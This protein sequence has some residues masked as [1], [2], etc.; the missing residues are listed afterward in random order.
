MITKSGLISTP[1]E[2]TGQYK[3]LY[4]YVGNFTQTAIENT[5][6]LNAELFNEKVDVDFDNMT[7]SSSAK[8]TIVGW[9]LPDFTTLT[10]VS[11]LPFTATQDCWVFITADRNSNSDSAGYITVNGTNL[12]L[13]RNVTNSMTG[14]ATLQIPVKAGTQIGV[15]GNAKFNRGYWCKFSS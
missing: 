12:I 15:S 2:D 4:F 7:P 9:G 8:A 10:S 6:G 14:D 1:A 13:F 3:Y 11:S 5:A